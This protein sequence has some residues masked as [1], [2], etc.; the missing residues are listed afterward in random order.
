[1]HLAPQ[2]ADSEI[3]LHFRDLGFAYLECAQ[4][5][6]G[7][8][9]DGAWETNFHRGQAVMW[10]AFH[11]TELLLKGCIR[12]VAPQESKN[13]HSLGALLKT[14][15]TH[16]PHLPFDPPFGPEIT[17]DDPETMAWAVEVDRTLH[18]QLRYPT[19]R[20]G[21][22]WRCE[23]AF[24]PGLFSAELDRL[25]SDIERISSAVFGK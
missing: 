4:R 24:E 12:H 5:L 13:V 10:L 16:F 18:E 8:M 1:M 25:R 21:S 17:P 23:R 2:Y 3:P 15:S 20:A 19:N 22:Q 7:E 14:F 6:C 11:A 9:A